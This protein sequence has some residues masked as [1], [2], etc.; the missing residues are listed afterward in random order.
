MFEAADPDVFEWY[1]YKKLRAGSKRL[2][3]PQ[4]NCTA[5]STTPWHL[6]H[7]RLMGPRRYVR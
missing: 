1:I 2:R 4:P 7:E 5:R 6:G 3:R